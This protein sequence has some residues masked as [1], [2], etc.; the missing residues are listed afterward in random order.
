MDENQ[1]FGLEI[2]SAR[3]GITGMAR[4]TTHPRCIHVYL[5]YEPTQDDVAALAAVT[6]ERDRL[7]AFN[8][9]LD[10][11]H[12]RLTQENDQYHAEL[13]RLRAEVEALKA[14]ALEDLRLRTEAIE[15]RNQ[16]VAERNALAAEVEALRAQLPQL[17]K[18]E[19]PLSQSPVCN[20]CDCLSP[21]TCKL[22]HAAQTKESN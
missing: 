8:R 22:R 9:S 20:G 14:G 16:A 15:L 11:E 17:T 4:D 7:Q 19:R 13:I 18:T 6:A 10:A 2:R 3:P 21:S 5:E 1:K 12:A